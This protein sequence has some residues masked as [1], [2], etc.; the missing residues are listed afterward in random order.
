M[1]KKYLNNKD[2]LKQIHISKN[3]YCSF[4]DKKYSDFD[5]I[6]NSVEN[7]VGSLEEGKRLRSSRLSLID[8]EKSQQKGEKSKPDQFYIDESP[9]SD[10]DVVFRVMTWD[11]IPESDFWTDLKDNVDCE[12]YTDEELEE[13]Y[14]EMELTTKKSK[15][16][17][18]VNFPPFQHYVLDA[19]R[20]PVCV[21][22]SHWK[23][24]LNA[25]EFS[26]WHGNMTNELAKM[27]MTLC[28]RY[29]TR[30]NWRGYSY[31]E[32]MKGYAMV[33][34]VHMGLQFDESKSSN[35]FAYY[36]QALMNCF[37]RVLNIEKNH[38]NIRD[39]IL[40]MNNYNPSFSRQNQDFGEE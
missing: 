8:Y 21:G 13:L 17:A 12:N 31:L 10:Q 32:E 2:L 5:I 39:D 19:D 37:R 26:R 14:E 4:S 25:G 20:N 29:A 28:D 22:K 40:V 11:H 1:A 6:V 35:P 36:T 24:D 7:I 3:T 30:G 18:S 33:H 34:F 15:R 23:G 16:H 38:Q 27:L 9:I